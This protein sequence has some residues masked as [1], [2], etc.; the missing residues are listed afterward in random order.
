[1]LTPESHSAVRILPPKFWAATKDMSPGEVERLMDAIVELVK[2]GDL[3]TLT[4]FDFISIDK[5]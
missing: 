4:R 3:N 2:Q 5:C 1:M